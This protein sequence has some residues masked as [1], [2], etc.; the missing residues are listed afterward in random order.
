MNEATSS[1]RPYVRPPLLMKGLTTSASLSDNPLKAPPTF[2]NSLGSANRAHVEFYKEFKREAD[3][4]DED[5]IK[6][7]DDETTTTLIFVSLC[8]ARNSKTNL[9]I[10]WGHRLVCFLRSHPLSSST[11]RKNS[12]LISKK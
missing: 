4:Y 3:E 12:N 11:F 8:Y 6:K 10:F 1:A 7:Y 2:P 5:F 9:S